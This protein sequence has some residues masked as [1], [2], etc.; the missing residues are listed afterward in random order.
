MAFWSRLVLLILLSGMNALLLHAQPALF[1]EPLSPRIANYTID[2]TL[3]DERKTLAGHEVLHWRNTSS[4]KL[5][6]LRLHLYLNAFKNNQ[7]TFARESGNRLHRHWMSTDGWGWID[8][9]SLKTETGE[10]LTR[11]I[12]FI[13]P[14]DDN[15]LDRTV[16]RIPLASPLMPNQSITLSLDF[17]A[18]LPHVLARTGYARDFFMV[19]QWFPKIGVYESAGQRYATVGSWNC[20]QFHA[21]SEFYADFGVYN[22]NITLPRRYVVGASG[23]QF[24]EHD[25]ANDTKTVSFHAE[26]VHDFAWTA[27]PRFEDLK[28]SWRHVAIHVLIQPEHS[29]QAQRYLTSVKAALDYFETH[30]GSYPYSTLTIVDPPFD[31][32][33]AGGM[34]YPTLITVGTVWGMPKGLLMP[35]IVTV[36]E[37][38]HQYWYGMSASNEFEEA[39]LDEGVNQYYE[40]RIMASAYGEQTSFVNLFGLRVGDLEYSRAG[41]T[42]MSNPSLAAS[43]T[44]SWKFPAGSY[45][46]LTYDKTATVLST[47]ERMIGTA[48]MDS[49][50][51]TF[52]HRWRFRHP[53]GKDFVATF[54]EL[55][56]KIHGRTFG[57]SMD[58]FF[59]QTLF[60]TA[61]CDYELSAIRNEVIPQILGVTDSAGHRETRHSTVLE[62]DAITYRSTVGVTRHGDLRLPVDVLVGF[63]N[64]NK[65]HEIWDGEGS[66]KE[67]SYVSSSRIIWAKIDPERK[68]LLDTD[69]NNNSRTV[70]STALPLWKYAAKILF[71]IQNLIQTVGIIG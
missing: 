61:T 58:W 60:G 1:H 41:Y 2:A 63:E 68:I 44:P 13:H 54:N 32:I 16:I 26:D 34:E 25:N 5:R 40:T 64:G 36:H 39:W 17:V 48:A 50:M 62:R 22:V 12:E 47:L 31:G 59:D 35:E 15:E 11:S 23:V 9:T 52:F 20:H 53:C 38:G 55:V 56:P 6:E 30:V 66:Y 43:A 65:V 4:D 33:N 27:F 28:D 51:K 10:D 37:F 29:S 21:N 67:L 70:A 42:G 14:D 19:G 18:Q 69:L 24:A 8:V 7:S 71:W 45:G 57:S 46:V 49:V 3:N